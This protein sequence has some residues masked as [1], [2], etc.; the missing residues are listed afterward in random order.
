MI[1]HIEDIIID[2]DT[3]DV[4]YM[5]ADTRNWW[6]GEENPDLAKLDRSRDLDGEGGFREPHPRSDQ[7]C[8]GIHLR[9]GHRSE[10]RN[11]SHA[12]YDRPGYW[13]DELAAK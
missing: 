2:S 6:G 11:E 4:R 10:L 9:L 5:I 13:V 3:W 1:S 8:A 12:H 7:G